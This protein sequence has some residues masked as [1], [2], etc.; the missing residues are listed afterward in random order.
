MDTPRK[1]LVIADGSE[2]ARKAAFFAAARAHNTGGQVMLL[3]V[4]ETEGFEAW[5]GVGEAMR[6][7][8]EQNAEAH[9]ESLAEDVESIT[10]VRPDV[11]LRNGPKEE[12][13]RT[14]IDEN[15]EIAILCL[16]AS[17]STEGAG[18]LV[19]ALAR[20]RLFGKRAI[21]VTVVPGELDQATI[22]ALC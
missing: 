11:A 18:P 6:R 2:E 3:A 14:L 5:M 21:P 10:G 15:V 1:F 22:E 7:E 8:A 16:G 12:A 4:V 20:Q 17:N 19:S 9:I 13:L